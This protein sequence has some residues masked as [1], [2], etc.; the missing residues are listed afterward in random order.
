MKKTDN[1]HEWIQ[2]D[3]AAKI[4]PAAM[5]GNWTAIFRVSANL[6]EDIDPNCLQK[7]LM[8][9]LKRFPGFAL[10]LRRGVFWYYL[11]RIEQQPRIQ[12]DV[13]NPCVRMDLKDNGGVMFRVRYHANRIALE[14][15]H[16]LCDGTGGIC[17]LETL[18]AE[19]LTIR[20]GAK[21]PRDERILDCTQEPLSEEI[22]DSF[23]KYFRK[24]T[25]SRSEAGSY[26]IKGTEE[27][28]H[29]LNIITGILSADTVHAKAKQYNASVT[30]L[31]VSLLI[32]SVYKVQQKEMR[33]KLRRMPVK[34]CVPV[35]LRKY[36]ASK[37]MRNFSSFVNPGIYPR[38]GEYSLEET[39]KQV[40][41]FMGMETSEKM[42]NARIS[43][44]VRDELNPLMRVVPLF[45]KNPTMKLAFWLN[46]DR[47]SSTTL[48]NLGKVDLPDEM[49][50]YVNRLD[51]MLGS[52]KFN[53]VTCAC[54][55]YN[56]LMT[57]NFTRNIKESDIER[58]FFTSMV[59]MGIP[60]T[61]ES[62]R[63]YR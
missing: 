39:V 53:P 11:E 32:M 6:S 50:K 51:F 56:N 57:I 13:A 61:V 10:R 35:N 33:R 59:K 19:Y 8:S 29:Y 26:R 14:V 55:T 16:V 42:I 5:S 36:Y 23:K 24:E 52:L 22:E 54:V 1:T 18:V 30:E 7:A 21:I 62:N 49:S 25:M 27:D 2:L 15:F 46:G 40:K 34:I 47:T 41:S 3:N 45:I 48:S 4:Y 63:R 9:T 60:V 17:F 38:L 43:T 44:N 12:H 58:E 31:L 28:P 37:T 20:Y